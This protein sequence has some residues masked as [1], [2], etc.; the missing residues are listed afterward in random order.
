MNLRSIGIRTI[1]AA[2]ALGVVVGLTATV[3][4]AQT[5]PTGGPFASGML[6]SVSGSA[7]QLQRT[8]PADQSQT[9]DVS[10]TLTG[11]TMYQQVQQTSPNAI[12]EGACVRVAGKGSVAKG[13]ITASTVA[14]TATSS[15]DCTRPR[16]NGANGG[17]LAGAGSA[18]GGTTPNGSTPPNGSFPRNGN[19]RRRAGGLAFGS[20]QS[21][22]GNQ[23]VVKAANFSGRR[24]SGGSQSP[25]K[26]TTKNVKVTLSGSTNVTQLVAAGQ[27]D[28]ATGQCVSAAGTGDAEAITAQRVTISPPENGMCARFGFGGGPM[29]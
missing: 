24:P 3:A 11:S 26:V 28:L 23:V 4:G 2:S 27:S 7:L 8:D 18:P 12:T 19:A 1:T 20:V 6:T 5:A 22:K 10:V 14:I 16:G 25:P 13:K 29:G 21:V 17:G 15:S 9:T